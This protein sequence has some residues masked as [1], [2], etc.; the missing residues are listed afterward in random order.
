ML[1]VS[2]V[3]I[4]LLVLMFG[5]AQRETRAD[6]RA[7]PLSPLSPAAPSPR[8]L[9]APLPRPLLKTA[10]RLKVCA[11]LGLGVCTHSHAHDICIY[12]DLSIY[13][14]IHTYMR[15]IYT[16]IYIDIYTYIEILTRLCLGRPLKTKTVERLKV[17]L[18]ALS[19]SLSL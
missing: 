13:T 18:Y 9:G 15:Y 3:F 6:T 14:Y 17:Y 2:G 12:I 5:M 11:C 1:V 16:H 7:H 4:S 8:T 19:L 10:E